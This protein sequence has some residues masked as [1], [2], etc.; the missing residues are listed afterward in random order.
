[1]ETEATTGRCNGSAGHQKRK[2]SSL[3]SMTA[4]GIEHVVDRVDGDGKNQTLRESLSE[5]ALKLKQDAKL[6]Q[7]ANKSESG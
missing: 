5:C 4:E 6:R 7:D 1:M 2:K 3:E